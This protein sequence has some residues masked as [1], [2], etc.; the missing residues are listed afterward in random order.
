MDE[1]NG[2]LPG[3]SVTCGS[4]RAVTDVNG[5]FNIS[6]SANHGAYLVF[7][8][9]GM[10]QKVKISSKNNHHMQIVMHDDASSLDEVVVTGYQ[11][12]DKRSL[13]SAVTSVKAEDVLRSDVSSIDQMLEGKVPD[14]LVSN[15]SGEIGVAPKIRI[16]GTSTLVG[17]REPL[18][19]VDGVVV[20]DPVDISP[21]WC[22]P[23]KMEIPYLAKVVEH[24]KDN[25]QVKII[26]ISVDTNRKAW[27]NKIAA[28][29]PA[30][31]Q[32]IA[33][34]EQYAQISKD[35]G[36]MGIPRFIL[37]NKD[38]SI[39]DGDAM[40]PSNPEIITL[41]DKLAR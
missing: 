11:V 17:N 33:N 38:G 39:Y 1:T 12:L 27:E 26:S 35:W 4:N 8:Y 37:I 20:K 3:V 25:D 28:D 24:F 40:R 19:V 31:E 29:K 6:L 16:R 18:W 10:Q 13:T 41:L 36:I 5:N 23:C 32:Y 15:N 22:G 2:P 21:T 34:K 7:S 30:W 9:I 14:L